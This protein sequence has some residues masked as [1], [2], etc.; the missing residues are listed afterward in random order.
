MKLTREFIISELRRKGIDFKLT[1]S[2]VAIICPFHEETKPSCHISLGV[3][4]PIGIFHCLGCHVSGRWNKLASV[5][6]LR[7][8]KGESSHEEVIFVSPPAESLVSSDVEDDFFKDVD[9]IDL[10]DGYSWRGFNYKFLKSLGAKLLWT[11]YNYIYLMFPMTYEF[12]MKGYI[13]C[14]ITGNEPGP[15]Y[16]VKGNPKY[17]FPFDYVVSKLK[18]KRSI[19][20]VEGVTDVLRLITY[21][22]PALSILGTALTD[23]M[24][25][26]IQS[27]F[28]NRIILCFDGDRGG[29]EGVLGSKHRKGC[30]SIL[31]ECGYD[32]RVL[33]PPDGQD[34]YE[35]PTRYVKVLKFLCCV[36]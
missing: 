26:Q 6:G 24:L 5:L 16:W 13:R 14:K 32:V 11:E 33:F 17:L 23:V 36:R 34:P 27:L 19:V 18:P 35:M 10:P 1:S 21:R 31:E 22:I 25:E 20:L 30:A 12:E 9:V 28:V 3:K 8:I 4:V 2:S 29:Y 15:K 7:T